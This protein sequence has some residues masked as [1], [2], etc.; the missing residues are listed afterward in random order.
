MDHKPIFGEN[1]TRYESMDKTRVIIRVMTEDTSITNM[2]ELMDATED[3]Q[4]FYHE[5]KSK[6]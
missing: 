3:G 6:E 4:S 1:A 2:E 5:I